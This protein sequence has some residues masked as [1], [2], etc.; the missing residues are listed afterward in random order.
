[1]RFACWLIAV[2]SVDMIC[3]FAVALRQR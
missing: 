2:V 3:S 1:V